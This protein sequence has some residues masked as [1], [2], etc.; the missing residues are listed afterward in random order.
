MVALPGALTVYLGFNAGGFFVGSQ[1]VI[2]LALLLILTLRVTAAEDP[3]GGLSG[4]VAV[5]AGALALYAVWILVSA[6]WSDAPSRA[7]LEFDRALLYLAALVLFGSFVHTPER[8]RWMVRLTAL[9]IVAV[10]AVALITRVLPDVWPVSPNIANDRLSYPLTYW[11]ALGLI[12][13]LG[14]VFCLYLASSHREPGAVRVL[15]SAA[16][17]VLAVTLLFTFSRGAIVA[18]AAALLTYVLLAKPRALL[19]CLLAVVPACGIAVAVA[20]SAD[21][22]ATQHPTTS[23][24][25]AQGH[26]V[27]LVVALCAGGAALLR[28]LLL[29]LDDRSDSAI[30]PRP[31][32]Q[33]MAGGAAALLIAALPFAVIVNAPSAI[34]RQYDRFVGQAAVKDNGDFR[35]RLTDPSNNHR[36]ELW[37]ADLD[38]FEADELTGHGAGTFQII[39][40]K[41]R[42]NTSSAVDGHSLYLEALAELGIVGLLLLLVAILALL[43][44]LV[45]RCRGRDR[46]LYAAVLAAAVAWALHASVDWDWEMPVVT[47]WLFALAGTALA[48]SRGRG[49]LIA[50]PPARF[51]RVLI[52]LGV[53]VLAVTPARVAISQ[54][55][56]NASVKEFRRGDCPKAIDSALSA[57]S[58]LGA[59]PEPYEV[60]GYC[61]SRLGLHGLAIRELRSAVQR[62]PGN[63]EFRYG[64]ALVRAA[65]GRDP[66]PAA[67]TTL[68]LNPRGALA[69]DLVLRFRTNDPASWRKRAQLAPLPG[70]L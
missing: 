65:A 38:A 19:G 29:R 37:G 67:R 32:P 59:R 68:R 39:W 58:V 44:G 55:R 22:L 21:L 46:A 2:A 27:A 56:L 48:A 7:L 25:V 66:R 69:R 8:L 17:P 47:L 13:S 36:L 30:L 34:G 11:N 41:Q 12:S 23:E 16:L 63:W 50:R 52:G 10:C 57:A 28:W 26:H 43:V 45:S 20:Y 4:P 70:D 53:L 18:G 24:A 1:A 62:D 31:S 6:A 5:A 49:R 60:L 15:G 54:A 35:Q 61:D 42:P 3:L 51:P 9:G 64:L 40:A 14:L 33:A